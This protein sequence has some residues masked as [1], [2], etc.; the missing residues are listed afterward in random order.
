VAISD[1][2]EQA[3]SL[4]DV[5]KEPGNSSPADVITEASSA[6]K[7]KATHDAQDGDFQATKRR[8]ETQLQLETHARQTMQENFQRVKGFS[9]ICH[10][11]VQ[12]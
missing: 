6:A 9:L 11:C 7:R 4:N 3:S 5:R 1:I 10:C 2:K 8:L 12:L